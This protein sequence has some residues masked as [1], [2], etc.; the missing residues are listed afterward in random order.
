[1]AEE[2]NFEKKVKAYLDSI[3]AWY[4]KTI[5]N[6]YQRA[7][8]PDLLICYK[9]KFIGIELKATRGRVSMLQE[10]EIRKIQAAGGYASVLRP[11]D[12]DSF[13]KFME[14][15][16]NEESTHSVCAD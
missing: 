5:S 16:G 6:G 14:E 3:G 11:N 8:V 9:G 15:I 4:L 13:K 1:M 12:F 2:K 10:H 7:G